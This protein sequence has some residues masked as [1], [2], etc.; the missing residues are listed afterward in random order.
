MSI[1]EVDLHYVRAI[2]HQQFQVKKGQPNVFSI[3][4]C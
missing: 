4:F 1:N 2:L 3:N